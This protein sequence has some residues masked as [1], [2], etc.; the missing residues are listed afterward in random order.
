MNPLRELKQLLTGKAIE[1]GK[2]IKVVEAGATSLRR[3]IAAPRSRA[4]VR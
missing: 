1:S 4:S 2:F 3:A